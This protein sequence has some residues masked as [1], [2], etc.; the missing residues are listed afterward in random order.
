MEPIGISGV[1]AAAVAAVVGII[2]G[3][4]RGMD[5]V[6]RRADVEL[7]KLVDAQGAR[8]ILLEKRNLELEQEIA[9]LR[10]EVAELR[11]ELSVERAITARLEGLA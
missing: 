5:N 4:R 9:D 3:S 8:I 11:S 10:R 6:A 1:V 2:V 7:Q